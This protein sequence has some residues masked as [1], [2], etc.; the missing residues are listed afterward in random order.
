MTSTSGANGT[1]KVATQPSRPLKYARR[2]PVGIERN[3]YSATQPL[4]KSRAISSNAKQSPSGLPRVMIANGNPTKNSTMIRVCPKPRVWCDV[5]K[6]LAAFS[7]E[8]LLKSP[9]GPIILSGWSYT[10]DTEKQRRWLEMMEWA[11][12]HGCINLLDLQDDD[13]YCVAVLTVHRIGPSGGVLKRPRDFETKPSP[14]DEAIQAAITLLSG[15][16]IEIVGKSLAA[17]TESLRFTGKK[18]RRLLVLHGTGSPPWG[19][20]DYLSH[21]ESK[22][23][24]FS[25]FRAAINDAI[26]PHEID[27]VD[28]T[29]K[30]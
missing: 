16:W 20:W 25:A 14:S 1:M 30:R 4:S 13:F 2:W 29:A 28:F 26:T 7:Q 27:H 5:H 9:P 22:R 19:E 3:V 17:V 23:R 11:T 24:T 18:K 10:N 21:L 8:H 12:D 15:R 6:R